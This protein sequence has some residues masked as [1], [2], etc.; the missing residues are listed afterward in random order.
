MNKKHWLTICLNDSVPI[1]EICKRID[2][3][4]QLATKKTVNHPMASRAANIMVK[5][6]VKS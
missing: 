3:S 2:R 6:P 4:R 1:E 5:V